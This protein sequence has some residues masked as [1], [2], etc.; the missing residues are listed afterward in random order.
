MH[1]YIFYTKKEDEIKRKGIN[2]KEEKEEK[3]KGKRKE[4]KE[5]G[6]RDT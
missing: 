6:R 1:L 4:R 2:K 3:G 5:E